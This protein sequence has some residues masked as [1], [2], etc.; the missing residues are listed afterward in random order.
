MRLG[1]LVNIAKLVF[2]GLLLVSAVLFVLHLFVEKPSAAQIESTKTHGTFLDGITINGVDVSGMT[3]AEARSAV[4]PQLD[5][6]LS[7][8]NI[9][10]R[11][12]S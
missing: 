4:L 12:G 6:A 1:R 2:F 11:H 3:R 10:V 7:S 8:I 5:A 9:T